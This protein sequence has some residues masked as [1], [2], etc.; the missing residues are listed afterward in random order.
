MI[1]ESHEK[2]QSPVTAN[3]ERDCRMNKVQTAMVAT[4]FTVFGICCTVGAAPPPLPQDPGQNQALEAPPAPP[5]GEKLTPEVKEMFKQ[6]H[7]TMHLLRMEMKALQA[8]LDYKIAAKASDEE[9]DAL[10][11]N[12]SELE[13][14]MTAES[15]K[16]R[17]EMVKKGLPDP[18]LGCPHMQHGPKGFHGPRG[19]HGPK[20]FHGHKGPHGPKGFHGHKGPHGPKGPHGSKGFHGP[21]GPRGPQGPQAP[22]APPVPP[23]PQ[24]EPQPAQ[25]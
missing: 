9:I 5:W 1:W 23:V 18:A 4:I 7:K 16:L 2:C 3:Q 13:G 6:H 10:V 17:R 22:P 24:G 21:K 11:K 15:V 20:G 12:I 19:P 8:N 14:K 25:P